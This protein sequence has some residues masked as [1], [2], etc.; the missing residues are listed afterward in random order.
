[1]LVPGALGRGTSVNSTHAKKNVGLNYW[2]EIEAQVCVLTPQKRILTFAQNQDCTQDEGTNMEQSSSPHARY[3]TV[4]QERSSE[5]MS[6]ERLFFIYNTQARLS[7]RLLR[8]WVQSR[9]V[10][11]GSPSGLDFRVVHHGK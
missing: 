1:M 10:I 3:I 5:T 9:C 7:S 2:F 6:N 8:D 11:I 4:V